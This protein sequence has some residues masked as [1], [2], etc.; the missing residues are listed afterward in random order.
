MG[1]LRVDQRKAIWIV[2]VCCLF[3]P[4]SCCLWSCNRDEIK[5]MYKISNVKNIDSI[6]LIGYDK[7]DH[8]HVHT[9]QFGV[10]GKPGSAI[11]V[12]VQ[13]SGGPNGAVEGLTGNPE[14]LWLEQLGPWNLRHIERRLGE[15]V[16][17]R[18]G[19]D[20]GPKGAFGVML[21]VRVRDI[22]DLVTHYDELVRFFA[23]WPDE[24]H[25][26]VLVL[27]SGT[28]LEYYRIRGN[29]YSTTQ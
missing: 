18:G 13:Y 6:W 10:I 9:L 26:Q 12:G 7:G 5:R 14:H 21:P 15:V 29:P 16:G 25:K 8:Y 24:A 20:I 17:S 19:I 2:A 3:T 28:K 11:R 1:K 4:L 27:S 23:S 22:N